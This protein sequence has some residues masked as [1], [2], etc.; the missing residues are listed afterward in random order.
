MLVQDSFGQ[1]IVHAALNAPAPSFFLGLGCLGKGFAHLSLAQKI[2][3]MEESQVEAMQPIDEL[4]DSDPEA[5]PRKLAP[6]SKAKPKLTPKEKR[7]AKAK[8]SA[9]PKAKASSSS[10]LAKQGEGEKGSSTA[11]EKAG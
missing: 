4:T 5:P 9:S 3:M 1:I 8:V 7:A 10:K 2:C 11:A 6:K